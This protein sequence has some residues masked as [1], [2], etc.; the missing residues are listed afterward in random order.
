MKLSTQFWQVAGSLLPAQLIGSRPTLRSPCQ[1]LSDCTGAR[2]HYGRLINP[3]AATFNH[4][5][6]FLHSYPHFETSLKTFL[7]P[8]RK[9]QFPCEK[10]DRGCLRSGVKNVFKLGNWRL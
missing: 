4:S 6:R 3:Q 2:I 1:F 10:L 7:T 8:D 9:R 5:Q